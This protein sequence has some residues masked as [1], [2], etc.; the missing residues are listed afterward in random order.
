MNNQ[1]FQDMKITAKG[2]Q[3]AYVELTGLETLWFNTGTLCNL[4]CKN[5]YIEF[6]PK[7]DR[8]SY[9]TDEEV[10]AYLDEISKEKLPVKMIGLTGG[11]PFLN[12]YII[13]VLTL[14]LKSGLE[15]LVLT[16]A[17][18]VLKRHQAAL[19]ELKEKYHDKLHLRVSL[20]H[21]TE[22][23][24]DAERGEG[25]FSRTME[26]LKWLNENGFNLSLASRS[27]LTETHEESIIGH[28]KAL[29]DYGI[30]INLAEKLVVFPEMLSG[31][32][33]PE[34][35]TDCWN[36][37]DK[38]PAQQMCATERMIVKRKGEQKPVVMPCTLLAYDDKFV[39]GQS[40]KESEDKVYLNHRFCAEFCVLGGASCSSTN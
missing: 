3:R 14:I 19:L 15:V 24:H 39:M 12:P 34:I 40:L 11:E 17:N 33:V 22:E 32:D 8:L 9:I 31:R 21:F 18:R 6:S 25:A 23:I 20:D 36:I 28:E 5:C 26:Q 13:K 16:N 35:T 10:A 27:L 29:S 2:E 1:K 37:L 38:S 30:K 4:E 7:N